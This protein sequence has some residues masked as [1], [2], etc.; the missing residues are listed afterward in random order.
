M[1]SQFS[2]FFSRMKG[3]NIYFSAGFYPDDAK[4]GANSISG[5]P[6][7]KLY[8]PDQFLLLFGGRYND[9]ICPGLS[10]QEQQIDK[11]NP[12]YN[13]FAMKYLGEFHPVIMPCGKLK[14]GTGDPDTEPII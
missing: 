14:N 2:I 3:Y 7:L 13:R 1:E 4:E 11:L 5:H 6:L 8:N 10:Y 9:A 12:K